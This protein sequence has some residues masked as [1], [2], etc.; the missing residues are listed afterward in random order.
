[1]VPASVRIL[2]PLR[3]VLVRDDPFTQGTVLLEDNPMFMAPKFP[4]A[5][6]SLTVLA[7]SLF[8]W[9]DQ[10]DGGSNQGFRPEIVSARRFKNP[11]VD[12]LIPIIIK[13]EGTSEVRQ[14]RVRAIFDPEFFE[15][16][17][18]EPGNHPADEGFVAFGSVLE[19]DGVQV[20][21]GGGTLFGGTADRSGGGRLGAM[22]FRL[23]QAIG[24]EPK[25][26]S[27]IS[28]RV[29]VSVEDEDIRRFE[30]GKFSVV[31]Q[32]DSPNKIFN[33]NVEATD[34]SAIVTWG[35][36]DQ[37]L[38]DVVTVDQVTQDGTVLAS[39]GPFEPPYQDR[40][41]QALQALRDLEAAGIDILVADP[42]VV[43]DFL[44][45]PRPPFGPDPF[46]A[47][48]EEAKVIVKLFRERQ[49]VVPITGLEA[50]SFYKATIQ[51]TGL[52][53]RESPQE[54]VR[55]RTR[56]GADLRKLAAHGLDIQRGRKF[57]TVRF[58]TNRLV[59]TDY[60]ISAVGGGV[61]ESGEVNPDGADRTTFTIDGLDPGTD[62]VVDIEAELSGE[63]PAELP[64]G[65]SVLSLSKQI[66]TRLARK[67]L[68]IAGIPFKVVSPESAVIKFKTPLPVAPIVFYGLVPTDELLAAKVTQDTEVEDD[69]RF[70]WTTDAVTGTDHEINLTALDPE[71]L[72]RY[73]IEFE[74]EDDEGIRSFSTDAN[75][76]EQ[77][78]RD[79]QFTTP[80][81]DD[82][83]PPELV[84]G[85]RVFA[86][87]VVAVIQFRND[88]PTQA[89]AFVGTAST[90]D[91]PDEF[92]F[93]DGLFD[94]R[95]SIVL[96]GLEG[97]IDY[98]FRV[99]YTGANG[100]SGTFTGSSAVA[101]K[102]TSA[103]Q[104]PGGG[105]S[106]TTT[107][108]P[109]TQFPVILS[110]PTVSS[111]TH[112]TAIVE[113]TTDE[114]A[115]SDIEFGT[116]SLEEQE[117]SG[118][119]ETSH[120]I[121]L[122]GLTSGTTYQ[123]IVASTDAS[124]NGATQSA[125]A[126]FTTDP[127]ID[128]IAPGIVGTPS[129]SYKNDNSATVQWAT[130][131]E[132]TGEV[133]FGTDTELGF[134]RS[135]PETETDHGITL[136]NLEASTTYFYKVSSTDL[137]SNG[138]T[139]S[140][141]LSFTT[142]AAPDLTSPSISDIQVETDETSAILTWATDELAD[143]FVDFGTLSGLL[144]STVGDVSDVTVHEVT[145]TNLVAATTYFYTVG[146]IDRANNAPTE[147]SEFSFTTQTTADVTPPA[148]PSSLAGVAGS[149]QALLGW[150]SND[151][152]DLA[153]Y[154][155]ERRVADTG[156]FVAI[157]SGLEDPTYTDLGLTNLTTYEYRVVAV[158][159]SDNDS[160][161]SMAIT[162]TPASTAAP[163]SPSELSQTGA[164]RP[165]FRFANAEPFVA[166]ASLTY[167]VQVSTEA[168]FS[169]VSDS[170][171][172]ITEDS[173]GITTWTIT[174]DL[175]EG[176]TYYW[177]VRALEGALIG[178]WTDPQEFAAIAVS[179]T[180]DFNG[181]LEV[182]FDDFFAFIDVFGDEVSGDSAVFDLDSDGSVD[183]D[184]F[185]IFV[186]N[187]GADATSGKVWAHAQEADEEA[188]LW[189]E[190][191]SSAPVSQGGGV[192]EMATGAGTD[193]I[194]VRVWADHVRDLEAYG[195][196]VGYDPRLV[197]FTKAQPGAGPLLES[198]GGSAPLFGVLQQRKGELLVGNGLI[199]GESVSGHGLLA[200]LSFETLGTGGT[201]AAIA[202]QAYFE[203]RQAFVKGG[204]D[205]T[206]RWVRQVRSTQLLPEQ[207]F[208]GTNY[209]NPFN[210]STHINYSLPIA[211][212]VELKVYDVLGQHVRT[213]VADQ[214]H[215]AGFYSAVW[216]GR[217]QQN[218]RVGSGIY[219]YRLSTPAFQQTGRMTLLK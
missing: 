67:A 202:D 89:S 181:D 178:P 95:H 3:M 26:I 114:P 48:L 171:S 148:V 7:A 194:T 46:P 119:S 16:V 15:F 166:E 72:Y 103:L 205:E 215:P 13:V 23:I 118:T 11:Q 62:Y 68:N 207:F 96:S 43:R 149:E 70:S 174:R 145:L 47:L 143:S 73:K 169:N 129:I 59:K 155:L 190:A 55:F 162:V 84:E 88:V 29:A 100:V 111:K 8:L 25:A 91:T 49:H 204:D 9:A 6:L 108:V 94:H 209:P 81:A 122:S 64:S 21:S 130:D 106:F 137:S 19:E 135:L 105:G 30:P 40:S 150:D 187:F 20:A 164:L 22:I 42:D 218:H 12:D 175:V 51:S 61:V 39:L 75:G 50:D 142:D 124:G 132:T 90:F 53:G 66:K 141:V 180:A 131:E 85:P 37:G 163:S 144:T 77:W 93:S 134:I 92:D 117:T 4:I 110:G 172:G 63:I 17:S 99:E 182:N 79:L 107:N 192:S 159:R 186:D 214:Q 115:D 208:L 191:R 2:R 197:R 188:Q 44:G 87:D 153:G 133:E 28:V 78:S 38:D 210:P 185:F 177:R 189:L 176:S 116:E 146:S 140:T 217:D 168:D 128:L 83:F 98:Q 179:L 76:N 18:F 196:V 136:T 58:S 86:S 139:E 97:G 170:E 211:A 80:S 1:M 157:A 32:L 201:G 127:E 184:D 36:R 152:L 165:T 24:S 10:A 198:Q 41:P 125:Q 104:P 183:F 45:V 109:D 5:R 199:D 35:T 195:L 203:L 54:M 123:Y 167:T 193:R 161:A 112:D 69:S 160:G 34:R 147:S 57:I 126:V 65:D 151:E 102:A 200:E 14:T 31:A 121:M 216:D 120:K 154:R 71:T 113:W 138:P 213:L 156:S 56:R 212:V 206:V 33:V 158:D 52:S 60:S 173:D 101:G 82:L 219:F 27:V 74:L